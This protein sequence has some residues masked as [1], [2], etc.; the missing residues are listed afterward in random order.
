MAFFAWVSS[1]AI[2]ELA[3]LRMSIPIGDTSAKLDKQDC[4]TRC[5]DSKCIFVQLLD[6]HIKVSVAR[7]KCVC[8]SY[9]SIKGSNVC[10]PLH[11]FLCLAL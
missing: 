7:I 1:W 10:Q 5:N 3:S 2:A 9:M 4:L 11:K 6:R 8:E